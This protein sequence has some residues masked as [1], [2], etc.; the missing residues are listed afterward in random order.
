MMLAARF[1]ISVL[2][3]ACAAGR[4]AAASPNAPGCDGCRIL[5]SATEGPSSPKAIDPTPQTTEIEGGSSYED[6]D[7]DFT[8]WRSAYLEGVH[9][10]APREVI[11]GHVRE[12]ERFAQRDQE[13][14]GGFY[15][16]LADTWTT[17]VEANASPSHRILAK[18][19]VF[20]QLEKTFPGG[21]GLHAGLRHTEYAQSNTNLAL[22]TAERYFGNYRAAYTL[23]AGRPEGAGSAASHRFQFAYYYGDRSSMGIAY[24]F[25]KEVENVAPAGVLTT[26]VRGWGLLGRHWFSRH[27]AVSFEALWHE[28]GS[29]YNRRG[30]RAGLR[31]QF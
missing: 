9:R 21:W 23:Y 4:A 22:L 5:A 17:L 30:A 16:P 29:L 3:L 14:L 28:Q 31:Y 19:S 26:D 24:T 1:T 18:W 10:F 2:F 27:W 8:F 11:Y 13:L 25:G 20:G 7:N 15:Y 6:L 12:T